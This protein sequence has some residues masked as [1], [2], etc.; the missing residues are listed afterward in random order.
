METI[1]GK[2]INSLHGEDKDQENIEKIRSEI[3]TPELGMS[4]DIRE[5]KQKMQRANT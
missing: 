2:K 1:K 4:P 3:K 5:A